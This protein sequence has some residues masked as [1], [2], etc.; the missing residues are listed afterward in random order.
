MEAHW[1]SRALSW[2]NPSWL[3]AHFSPASSGPWH[4]THWAV[5]APC[6]RRADHPRWKSCTE[7]GHWSP[8]ALSRH[9]PSWLESHFRTASARSWH[10]TH[11]AVDAYWRHIAYLRK[12]WCL[13]GPTLLTATVS[14]QTP[15]H[16]LYL[17]PPLNYLT[18]LLA[19][20]I[21]I[22]FFALRFAP[23]LLRPLRVPPQ[24]TF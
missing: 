2:H 22:F 7:E 11:R 19:Q 1:R 21:P 4:R 5:E 18:I 12:T 17:I 8:G 23:R 16:P 15:N 3:D 13:T 24:F 6:Q 14:L 9:N 10:R 20:S